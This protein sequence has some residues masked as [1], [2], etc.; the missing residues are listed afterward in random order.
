M[1]QSARMRSVPEG[2]VGEAKALASSQVPDTRHMQKHHLNVDGV[3]EPAPAVCAVAPLGL[4]GMEG[5]WQIIFAHA[6]AQ[7]EGESD[8]VQDLRQACATQSGCRG[9]SW[10]VVD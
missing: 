6:H 5:A 1:K 3:V 9:R 7:L 4:V 10:L 8:K 2:H